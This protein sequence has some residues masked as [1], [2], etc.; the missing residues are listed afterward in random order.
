MDITA[1]TLPKSDQLNYDDFGGDKERT[2]TV[3]KVTPGTNEQPVNVELIESP[4][5]CYRPSKSM[6]RV[7]KAGWGPEGD[8]Y[9][10]RRLT[11]AGDPSIRFGAT[12]VGGIVIKAMSHLDGP[13]KVSLTVKKASRSV[14]RVEPLKADTPTAKPTPPPVTV[15]ELDKITDVEVLKGL[16]NQ[17]SS[18]AERATIIARRD[19]IQGS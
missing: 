11:L 10:G 17:A 13:L 3:G 8:D 7:L 15:E 16:Y 4:G 6:L 2:Y 19:A 12:A 9:E 14:Y 18:D 5:R 1:A